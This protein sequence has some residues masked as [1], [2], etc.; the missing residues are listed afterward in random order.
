MTRKSEIK[1]TISG[2]QGAGKTMLSSIIIAA[3][4]KKKIVATPGAGAT[5]LAYG[6]DAVRF[7][8]TRVIQ[9]NP[10]GARSHPEA[11]LCIRIAALDTQIKIA[12]LAALIAH[13]L[14]DRGM[15]FLSEPPAYSAK[16]ETE[17]VTALRGVS[18]VVD[19]DLLK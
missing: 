11:S 14:R 19:T 5:S 3:L 7:L 17:L 15:R 4:A 18:F 12:A 16:D 13:S 8:R 6:D 2:A 1:I 9:I 10:R